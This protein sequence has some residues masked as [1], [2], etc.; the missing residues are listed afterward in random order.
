MS[1]FFAGKQFHVFAFIW[2]VFS[3]IILW[4][5]GGMCTNPLS[6]G[7]CFSSSALNGLSNI[8]LV[9]FVLP[10]NQWF[11]LM[12][13]FAPVAGFVFA[14]Y[15]LKWY[16]EY[17]ESTFASSIWILPLLVFVLL[18][19][20]YINLSWYYGEAAHLNT[21]D[22]VSVGLY[23]CLAESGYSQCDSIV[24]KINGELITQAEKSGASKVQQFIPVRYWP[25]L[26]E[27]IFLTFILGAIAGWLPLFLKKFLSKKE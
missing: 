23:F 24:N 2:F 20:Y 14:Y 21:S 22:Q 16:N 15:G 26:R 12:Y 13:W 17:F 6:G 25:E 4:F 18:A 19:G 11:S 9:N 10:L 1:D 3:Y 8:P 27:S 5:L 7:T